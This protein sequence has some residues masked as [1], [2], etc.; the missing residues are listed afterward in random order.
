M[1]KEGQRGVNHQN[2]GQDVVQLDHV[3]E[4]EDTKHI[5]LMDNQ[6]GE[7]EQKDHGR[8]QPMPEPLIKIIHVDPLRRASVIVCSPIAPGDDNPRPAMQEDTGHNRQEDTRPRPTDPTD[9]TVP[10]NVQLGR[11]RL[12]LEGKTAVGRQ[13]Q[14]TCPGHLFIGQKRRRPTKEGGNDAA[15]QPVGQREGLRQAGIFGV[16]ALAV[17]TE[18]VAAGNVMADGEGQR[19]AHDARV[20]QPQAAQPVGHG[21]NLRVGRDMEFVMV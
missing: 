5:R 15:G 4:A 6:S 20:I 3:A 12:G 17:S 7:N 19:L 11:A 9:R 10:Q 1:V 2:G 13:D 8:L 21:R 14:L 16:A 18:P